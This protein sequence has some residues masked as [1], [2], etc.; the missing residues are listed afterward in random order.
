MDCVVEGETFLSES[1]SSKGTQHLCVNVS[2]PD[3]CVW[4]SETPATVGH[5]MDSTRVPFV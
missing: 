4:G 5:V 2:M 1:A 3:V